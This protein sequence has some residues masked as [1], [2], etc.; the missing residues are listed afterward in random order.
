MND[1]IVEFW[2]TTWLSWRTGSL[3]SISQDYEQTASR[4]YEDFTKASIAFKNTFVAEFLNTHQPR[5]QE[6]LIDFKVVPKD[7][8]SWLLDKKNML[9]LFLTSQRLWMFDRQK[10]Q[11]VEIEIADIVHLSYRRGWSNSRLTIRFKD[12]TECIYRM[13][14]IPPSK[15]IKLAIERCSVPDVWAIPTDFQ[16]CTSDKEA[17]VPKTI[18]RALPWGI[19]ASAAVFFLMM[20]KD[21]L[22]QKGGFIY[23]IGAIVLGVATANRYRRK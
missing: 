4:N 22:V 12:S 19:A 16:T 2:K 5:P 10:N 7:L 13:D 14:C 21:K 17:P 9:S 20:D 23:I 8:L 18:F 15:A 6:V 3:S 11:Y 1:N